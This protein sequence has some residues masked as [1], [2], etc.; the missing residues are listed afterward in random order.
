MLRIRTKSLLLIS[1]VL[2]MPRQAELAVGDDPVITALRF[3]FG[4]R[5]WRVDG[6]EATA[7]LLAVTEGRRPS[8]MILTR[9]ADHLSQHPGEVAFPGGWREPEDATLLD[10]ALRETSEELG[11]PPE[12]V[13]TLGRLPMAYTRRTVAVACFVGIVPEST[14]LV[15]NR[16]ELSSVFRV[17]LAFF[18]QDNLLADDF[19]RRGQRLLVPRFEFEGYDI[20]GLTAS[21]IASFCAI[22]MDCPLD[23]ERV[24]DLGVRR[25]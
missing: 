14:E 25:H 4:A 7:V 16:S 21:L 12:R 24:P 10:T 20:W 15:V 22:G 18:C 1:G 11:V 19:E 9:R 13:T 5:K 6:A 23:L 17:P 3:R 8:E 2:K